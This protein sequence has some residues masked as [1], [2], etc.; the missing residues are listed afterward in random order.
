MEIVR[1]VENLLETANRPGVRVEAEVI[2]QRPPGEL[3]ANHPLVE[4]A[5]N[6]LKEQGIEPKLMV[7]STDANV[8]LS[9]GLP[10]V[11]LGVTNGAGAHTVREF[12]YTKP[13]GHGMQQLTQFVSR[14]WE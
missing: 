9:R 8:P 4:L 2:G 6:C 11:V 5:K 12:I 14:V 3:P 1:T 7:G 13:V 10:G